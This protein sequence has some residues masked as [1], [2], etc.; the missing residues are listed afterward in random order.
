MHQAKIG[1]VE[2]ELIIAA[3]MKGILEELNYIVPEPCKNY[4]EAIVMLET[5]KPD[6]VILDIQL[7]G[8]RDGVMVAEYITRSIDIPFIFHS[9]SDDEMTV[10]RV[11]KVK[12]H[13]FLT[14][15]FQKTD[16]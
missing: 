3:Y 6:L 15:P 4:E 13:A 11:K 12:P 8:D 2:D 9:G 10:E 7:A 1:I 5:E 14:K 16:L